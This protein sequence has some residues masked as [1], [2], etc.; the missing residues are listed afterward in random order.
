MPKTLARTFSISVM[1][2]TLVA[3]LFA[4]SAPAFAAEAI[5]VSPARLDEL[6]DPGNVI[7]Q[8]IKVINRSDSAK[9]IHAYIRDF[10][11]EG[12]E[13]KAQLIKPGTE[14]GSFLSSWISLDN[15]SLEFAP[16]E[17]KQFNFTISVPQS[18]GPGGYYGALV[19]GT[20]APDVTVNS[21][22]KGAAIGISQQAASLIL[23]QIS[24][25]VNE[26]A[27]IREFVADKSVYLTPFE[28]KFL[29]RVENLGNVHIKPRGTV[30]VV[31][32]LNNPVASVKINDTGA[33]ILPKST[34]KFENS[35]KD[36][37][38]FGRYK[39][40]LALSY[41]TDPDKGGQGKQT[42]SAITYFWIIPGK[43]VL[44]GGSIILVLAIIIYVMLRGYKN[45][46]IKR[47][48]KSMGNGRNY[49]PERGRNHAQA[50]HNSMM[51]LVSLVVIFLLILAVYF[52]FIA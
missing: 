14:Q 37:F 20:M 11:S 19:F 41:G 35:W 43:L 34:R 21:A 33:N 22:E 40:T 45:R 15:E 49:V 25:D 50:A 42:L 12:E 24:G 1:A 39:A 29:A 30:E 27:N 46:A 5:T 38:G 4:G 28:T 9:T 13:G 51:A 18:A 6:V 7:R 32:M 48:I 17:E 2:F 52:L 8:S 26:S 47:A 31:N 44:V 23:L 10:K 3:S 16:N 36:G